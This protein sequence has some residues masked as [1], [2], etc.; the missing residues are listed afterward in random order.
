MPYS[1]DMSIALRG[2]RNVAT[3][4]FAEYSSVTNR[5]ASNGSK[6]MRASSTG[7][8]WRPRYKTARSR[9]SA[10]ILNSRNTGSVAA[11]TAL[12]PVAAP[13][14]PVRAIVAVS[15]RL[16]LKD[17]E[18]RDGRRLLLLRQLLHV[19]FHCVVHGGCA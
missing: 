12:G 17:G 3:R 1:R 5:D 16:L 6:S 11:A 4:I 10:V 9:L 15:V 13:A 19:R 7:L 18:D 2:L 14:A 8:Q